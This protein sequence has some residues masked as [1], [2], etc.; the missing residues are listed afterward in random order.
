LAGFFSPLISRVGAAEGCDPLIWILKTRSKDRSFQ[1]LLHVVLATGQTGHA[2]FDIF[3][4]HPKKT[5]RRLHPHWTY[6]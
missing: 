4:C 3:T 2:N 6:R 5:E 1:Q